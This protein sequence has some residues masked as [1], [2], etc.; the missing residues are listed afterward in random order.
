[1]VMGWGCAGLLMLNTC[2]RHCLATRIMLALSVL[3]SLQSRTRGQRRPCRTAEPP[4]T[5]DAGCDPPC[6]QLRAQQA[7]CGRH[8]QLPRIKLPHALLLQPLRM[9]A[10]ATEPWQ[11]KKAAVVQLR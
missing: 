2:R 10:C 11:L 6:P 8:V 3:S 7:Q 4:A 1:M 9:K 5:I